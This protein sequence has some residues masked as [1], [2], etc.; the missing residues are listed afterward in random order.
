MKKKIFIAV[1]A[2]AAV[3]VVAALALPFLV[4]ANQFSPALEST[5]SSALGRKVTIGTVA[6]SLFSGGIA[7]NDIAIAED[8]AF[9]SAPF[10]R[11]KSVTIGIEWLPLIL[12]RQVRVRSFQLIDKSLLD[13]TSLTR[14]IESP[15]QDRDDED[16]ISWMI[17]TSPCDYLVLS[18]GN[19]GRR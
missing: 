9:G 17:L 15:N 1:A 10:V 4:D 8:P 14:G 18:S 12:S 13:Y 5:L 19:H 6:V 2:L 7:V 16:A 11:A 3:I